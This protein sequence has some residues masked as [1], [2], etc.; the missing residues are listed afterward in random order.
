MDKNSL[1]NGNRS[2]GGFDESKW[3]E[4]NGDE[5]R[6]TAFSLLACKTLAERSEMERQGGVRYS[7]LYRLP[8]YDPIRNHVIDPMHNIFLGMIIYFCLFNRLE[9]A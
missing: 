2:I 5:H 8:Y 6:S 1:Q 3:T 7:D 9:H 4:R